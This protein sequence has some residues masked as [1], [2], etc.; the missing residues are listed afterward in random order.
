MEHYQTNEFGDD[1]VF[2]KDMQVDIK[3]DEVY[4]GDGTM[5]KN[6]YMKTNQR[7]E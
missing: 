6:Y 2:M 1:Q 3:E 7:L 4:Y 5:N